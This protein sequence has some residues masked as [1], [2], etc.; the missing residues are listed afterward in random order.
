M[1]QISGFSPTNNLDELITE[2]DIDP[3]HVFGIKPEIHFD[4]QPILSFY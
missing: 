4:D 2:I 1:A 3:Y